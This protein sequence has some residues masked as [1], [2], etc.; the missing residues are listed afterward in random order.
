VL[1]DHER[2][3]LREVER[4]FL[5]E[6]PEFTRSFATRAQHLERRHLDGGLV[7]I[8]IVA[9]VLLGAL[10]LVAG[11]PSGALAMAALAGLIW[12]ARR[13]SNNTPGR[14]RRQPPTG[15]ETDH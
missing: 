10:M 4:Q 15:P 12:L 6:D 3:T 8:A 9:A 14:P 2:K 1:N 11:S 7:K 5:A 13:Q